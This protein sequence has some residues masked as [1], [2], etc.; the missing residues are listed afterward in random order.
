MARKK[1]LVEDTSLTPEQLKTLV[2]VMKDPFF[3]STFCYVINPVLGMVKFLLYPFQKAVLYQFML[4]RFNIILKFRQAGITE[5]ISLYCLWLAMYHPNKKINIISIKDT[6]AKKVLKKIKFMYKNL[7]SYLQEP[8]IN[9]RAGEFGSV[10]T[11][12]FANGSVIESIPT[13]DQAGRSESLSL[14]VIDEAAIVRW[15]STIWASAFPTLSTGGSAIVNSCITGDTQIIGKDGPF[16]VDSICPK[17]FGKMDI[18]HLGLRVLSHTGKWQRVLGSVNKGILKTWEVH[19][20]QGRVIKCTPKHKLYTLEGWLPVSEII[21]RDIP[22]IF[23]HTGISGLEQNPVTVK[24][25]KEIC[26]PI[27]GYPNYEVSNWGRIFIVKNGTRVEKLPRPCNN[28][29]RYLNIRLWNKG[30]KKKICV[31]NLVAKVF[32]G[33][34]PDGYVVDHIN[35]NPSDNYVTNLQ[36]VTVAENSQKAAKYSYGMKLGS[37]LK[38]GFNYD[39]RVVAYIRYRYQELGYYYGVLDK[40]SKEVEYKFGVK[41]N[42]PYIQRIVSGKRC[43]SIYLSKL[44]VVRKYYDTIYDICVEHDESYLINED[45]VSHNTPYG[46][47]SFFHSTWVDALSGGNPFNPIRLYWQMHPDRDEKWYEEMSAALGPKR[48]AQEIDGDFLSSGNTVFDLADIKAIEECLFDYPVI[49]TRLK[50]Q[51]KEFNEPDPNKEYFIGGD[52]ATGRGTDYSAFTCMDKEGE[53][54]AVYKGRIPLNKYAR[55]LGDVGE[56]FNFAK[57]APE[58]N[59]VGMTVTTILQDEGYPNLYFYTKLLRKKRK[60]RPEED[61]FPGWLTTTKNRSVII[62]NLEKDIREENVIIKDPFFVQEAY[63]FIYDGAGRP[64]ARGKHRMNNSSMDLDLE[65]ET[66]SDDAIFGKAITN[67]IR[68]HSPSGTVVIPQ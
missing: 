11:M 48:T 15:A 23:Y 68:S 59:D 4:N 55:L 51:Y 5:L 62:E 61:K 25:K 24:P 46:V 8:I 37:K 44:K 19:N 56:K 31:H 36:I 7:P 2:R 26:K 35:N 17:T 54:A 16:R 63:T 58:T 57:L 38:G 1:T 42:K 14:L 39:L 65:G 33:E 12:E 52:C 18:S 3:F 20:E 9:G 49:N 50:G 41:L 21:K 22:A 30:Q 67:H 29:E 53:E 45:Y 13:S 27:P 40:I 28:R 43:T 6:V 34:I 10:S 66:Y 47:G 64:I 32:L 60:N